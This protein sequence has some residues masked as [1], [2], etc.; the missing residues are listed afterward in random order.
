MTLRVGKRNDSFS[1]WSNQ[2]SYVFYLPVL[3]SSWHPP[4]KDKNPKMSP[5]KKNTELLVTKLWKQHLSSHVCNFWARQ[6]HVDSW[7]CSF[8]HF[9]LSSIPFNS[10]CVYLRVKQASAACKLKLWSAHLV[11]ERLVCA[12]CQSDA[13]SK[14]DR[15]GG[16]GLENTRQALKS[17]QAYGRSASLPG[18]MRTISAVS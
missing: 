16:D 7:L 18:R 2:T 17:K 14:S 1:F 10:Y 3:L 15:C 12:E 6:S 8:L 13:M 9:S 4:M 5:K 11:R